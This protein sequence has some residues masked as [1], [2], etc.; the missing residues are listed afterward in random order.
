M[1]K[2]LFWHFLDLLLAYTVNIEVFVIGV[3]LCLMAFLYNVPPL[4]AKDKPYYDVLLESVNN[5]LRLAI[6]WY[7]TGINV[8][9]PISL[10][11]AYWMI[12]AFF[13]AVK[14]F[15][16][17][18][19]INDPERAKLYRKS[20]GHYNEARLLVSITYYGVAFG[21]FFGIFLTRYRMELI[22][23]VPLIAGFIAWYIHMGFL[24]NSP[25]QSPEKLFKQKGFTAYAAL[26]VSVMT[27]LLFFD[28]PI[29]EKT[30]LPTIPVQNQTR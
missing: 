20:F 13:M 29:V 14:R 5:P 11:A 27:G 12:G 21:L 26:C 23:S 28:V 15:A 3:I 1:L 19:R 9:P 7:C 24:P 2:A 10:V 25:T 6:G 4:R 30:F 8:L 17:Y 22:L 16:E 18:R